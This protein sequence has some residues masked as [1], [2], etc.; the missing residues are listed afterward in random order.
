MSLRKRIA[1]IGGGLAGIAA[2]VR[3]AQA[4]CTPILIESR[5]RLG[6]RATSLVDPR[7]GET[8]DNCQHVLLGCCTNLI[9]LYDRLGVIDKIEWHSRLYWTCAERRGEIDVMKSNWLPAP[10]HMTMSFQRMKMFTAT[11]K[12]HIACGMWRMI[13]MGSK[14]RFAWTNR[15]FSEFLVECKQTDEVVRRFWNPIIVSACNLPVDRVG[16]AYAL[17]VFQVGFLANR[18]SYTMGLA[19]VPLAELYDP[20]VEAIERVGGEVR[21][22]CSAKAIAFDGSR[23]TGV[24]TDDGFIESSAVIAAV[25]FDRLE[26]LASESLVLADKRLQNLDSFEVSPILGV[27]FWFE[28][29]IMPPEIPHLVLAGHDV[30]WLFNK[31][32]DSAGIRGQHVHAVISAADDWMG[33]MED[34]IIARVM[35]DVYACLPRS[36]GLQPVKSRTIKEKRATFS[37]LPGVDSFRP[38]ASAAHATGGGV[39]NLFLAGDWTDTGWPATME[40]AVRSGYAAAAEITGEEGIIDDVPAGL[41]AQTLGLR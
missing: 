18:W 33:M 15:R 9:D 8:I 19:S 39:E 37:P 22:G 25:P 24:V 16:A 20:A 2:A 30:Q 12:R 7:S 17:Q 11:E 3:L 40:G 13:R 10:F 21:L 6:G 28:Q 31:G 35:K 5:K 41:L 29:P 26:K 34:E 14:G 32:E 23:V 36:I 38:S 4:E 1:I 27:H